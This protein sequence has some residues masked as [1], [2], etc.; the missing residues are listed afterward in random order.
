MY[1]PGVAIE[2][3]PCYASAVKTTHV[4][5]LASTLAAAILGETR[6]ELH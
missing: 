1:H 6:L 3:R 5:F 4:P 2:K